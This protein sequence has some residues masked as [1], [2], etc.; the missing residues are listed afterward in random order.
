MFQDCKAIKDVRGLIFP[1]V[2][3]KNM[4]GAMFR[5]SGISAVP[6]ELPAELPG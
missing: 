1:D 6:A 4:C 5:R 2:A 3:P